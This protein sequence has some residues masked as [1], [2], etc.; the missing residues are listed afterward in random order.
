[1]LYALVKEKTDVCRLK[2]KKPKNKTKQ[3]N[4]NN[5]CTFLSF[6]QSRVDYLGRLFFFFS[7]TVIC[8][9][10]ATYLTSFSFFFCFN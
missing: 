5:M 6:F 1:M 4:N 9:L 2:K 7:F 8:L 10:Y 3:N